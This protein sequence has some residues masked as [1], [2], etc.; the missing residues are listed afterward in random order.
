MVVNHCISLYMSD[1]VYYEGDLAGVI[2]KLVSSVNGDVLMPGNNSLLIGYEGSDISVSDYLAEGKGDFSG[3]IG[4]LGY[5]VSSGIG[6]EVISSKDKKAYTLSYKGSSYKKK[7]D[8]YDVIESNIKTMYGMCGGFCI[9]LRE[10]QIYDMNALREDIPDLRN[11]VYAYRCDE[12]RV[13]T[14]SRDKGRIFNNGIY[15]FTVDSLSYG[16]DIKEK[17]GVKWFEGVAGIIKG[18]IDRNLSL[19]MDSDYRYC[20]EVKGER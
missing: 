9:F 15:A 3:Y 2:K 6:V 14:G 18:A 10:I 4:V 11:S 1:S 17:K 20:M 13:I 19:N 16:Y 5:L 7:L 12:G 8:Y